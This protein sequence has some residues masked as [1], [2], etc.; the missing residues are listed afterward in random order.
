MKLIFNFVRSYP[1]KVIQKFYLYVDRAERNGTFQTLLVNSKTNKQ[2]E[3]VGH[4]ANIKFKAA[5]VAFQSGK[6]RR[7]QFFDQTEMTV[8]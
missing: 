6:Y 3:M 4:L 5:L 2:L 7:I 8:G 1:G